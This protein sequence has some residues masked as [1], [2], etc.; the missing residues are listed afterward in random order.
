MALHRWAGDGW[1][2]IAVTRKLYTARRLGS[3]NVWEERDF[4]DLK[5]AQQ[6]LAGWAVTSLGLNRAI[7]V[8]AVLATLDPQS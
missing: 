6:W 2:K 7:S 4:D 3:R 1:G 5:A 8:E